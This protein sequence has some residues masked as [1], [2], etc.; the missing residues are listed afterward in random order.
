MSLPTES[1]MIHTVSK[2]LFSLAPFIPTLYF[3]LKHTCKKLGEKRK[4]SP[5]LSRSDLQTGSRQKKKSPPP[6][7]PPARFYFI[8]PDVQSTTENTDDINDIQ[9][10]NRNPHDTI[11]S[12]NTVYAI[13][14]SR[15]FRLKKSWVRIPQNTDLEKQQWR[16]PLLK[17]IA[18][19]EWHNLV[20]I[21]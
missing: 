14:W 7:P 13:K 6:P 10:I 1:P 5:L 18:I 21:C 3:W 2:S 11:R 8:N 17:G 15:C 16:T 19:Y 12:T 4:R 9:S 20:T